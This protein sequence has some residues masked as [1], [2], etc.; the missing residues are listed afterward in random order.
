MAIFKRLMLHEGLCIKRSMLLA[1]IVL[2]VSA[3]GDAP[4]RFGVFVVRPKKQ[5]RAEW[6]SLVVYLETAIGRRVELMAIPDQSWM[7]P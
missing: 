4:L 7:Q 1:L 5:V 3:L 2:S 6:Q